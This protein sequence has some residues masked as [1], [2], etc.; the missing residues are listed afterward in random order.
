MP[1][2]VP[3]PLQDRSCV[4]SSIVER[5]DIPPVS[6]LT[7]F[8]H[9]ECSGS[10]CCMSTSFP[11]GDASPSQL[12][13]A[14]VPRRWGLLAGAVSL[15]VCAGCGARLRCEVSTS[16]KHWKYRDTRDPTTETRLRP[17]DD[18]SSLEFPPG[19]S[20]VVTGIEQ[21]NS[22]HRAWLRDQLEP[23]LKA[24]DRACFWLSRTVIVYRHYDPPP[25]VEA[26][27]E[28]L[29]EAF[30]T[31]KRLNR[32]AQEAEAAV[33]E[34][35]R[36]VGTLDSRTFGTRALGAMCS[37]LSRHVTKMRAALELAEAALH[38]VDCAEGPSCSEHPDV[39]AA[40]TEALEDPAAALRRAP[41]REGGLNPSLEDA[42]PEEGIG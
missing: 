26:P 27:P 33:I 3:Y 18:V 4:S 37:M 1:V 12:D 35:T 30:V 15:G 20:V 23:R 39:Y 5:L 9:V 25:L 11:L 2:P 7:L 19:R 8:V 36:G 38:C 42:K 16:E 34:K 17:L 21:A 22:T 29:A 14:G 31:I 32:R 10:P 28:D 24:Q 6:A 41:R 40:I 13:G